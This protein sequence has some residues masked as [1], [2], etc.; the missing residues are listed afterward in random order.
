MK[1]EPDIKFEADMAYDDEIKLEDFE[2]VDIRHEYLEVDASPLTNERP[3]ESQDRREQLI[4]A[5]RSIHL[6][7]EADPDILQKFLANT[8]SAV[9]TF[10][11][12]CRRK[13][14]KRLKAVMQSRTRHGISTKSMREKPPKC[15]GAKNFIAKFEKHAML[16]ELR[17]NLS[18]RRLSRSGFNGSSPPFPSA[19][20]RFGARYD[21][22][23][24]DIASLLQITEDEA[25]HLPL[26]PPIPLPRLHVSEVN[27]VCRNKSKSKDKYHRSLQLH[28]PTTPADRAKAKK[29]PATLVP[30]K[31]KEISALSGPPARAKAK[32]KSAS[33]VRAKIKEK[34]Q[35][36]MLG[37]RRK[38]LLLV[39]KEARLDARADPQLLE[40]YLSGAFSSDDPKNFVVAARSSREKRM[41]DIVLER[42]RRGLNEDEGLRK[43]E[44]EWVEHGKDTGWQEM[45]WRVFQKDLPNPLSSCPPA[46]PTGKPASS[47][48]AVEEAIESRLP[49]PKHA[50][51]LEREILPGIGLKSSS[52]PMNSNANRNGRRRIPRLTGTPAAQ[53]ASLAG[54]FVT[55]PGRNGSFVG[56][57]HC[58]SVTTATAP[59]RPKSSIPRYSPNSRHIWDGEN[60]N[61]VSGTY[62]NDTLKG[63]G[64]SSKSSRPLA[65]KVPVAT[66]GLGNA[67]EKDIVLGNNQSKK[68]GI[69]KPTATMKPAHIIISEPRA[70]CYEAKEKHPKPLKAA[71]VSP[72][73]SRSFVSDIHGFS[74]G[75]IQPRKT[76]RFNLVPEYDDSG[77]AKVE[78]MAHGLRRMR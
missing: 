11:M 21:I 4:M 22:R 36:Q 7:G 8:E 57:G 42:R 17:W 38:N 14:A 19:Q 70:M 31:A 56:I 48:A 3:A 62:A 41:S 5:A 47:R 49:A 18:R 15:S 71:L 59:T 76:L 68:R 55:L 52:L 50:D 69:P 13:A 43:M 26:I 39:A 72:K 29:K 40:S 9:W 73:S 24:P 6:D 78:K 28:E 67:K 27:F 25:L 16:C 61:P 32:K 46:H 58:P 33:A 23:Y 30:A 37:E 65:P 53:E 34:S 45:L 77:I 75:E 64:K 12:A 60:R 74:A 2:R 63:N 44:E 20:D 54:A 51:C 35:Q 66:E 1:E 10:V